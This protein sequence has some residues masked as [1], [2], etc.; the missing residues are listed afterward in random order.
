MKNKWLDILV[1]KVGLASII[2]IVLL[3]ILLLELI[4]GI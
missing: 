4:K 1:I 2:I 3:Y